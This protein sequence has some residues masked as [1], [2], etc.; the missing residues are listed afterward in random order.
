MKKSKKNLVR[1]FFKYFIPRENEKKGKKRRKER[2]AGWSPWFK[3]KNKYGAFNA[4]LDQFQIENPTEYTQF[5][6]MGS[7]IFNGLLGLIGYPTVFQ[8]RILLCLFCI[9][10]FSHS[11]PD[12]PLTKLLPDIYSL[13]YSPI[14]KNYVYFYIR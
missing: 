9:L 3:K 2:V 8:K 13:F 12:I 4:L 5:L 10:F 11:C 1:L 7:D 14:S 6:R